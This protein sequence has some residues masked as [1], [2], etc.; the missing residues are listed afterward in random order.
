MVMDKKM[1]KGTASFFLCLC[2]LMQG[3]VAAAAEPPPADRLARICEAPEITVTAKEVFHPAKEN[4]HYE[5]FAPTQL[6][7]IG[8]AYYLV[9]S[10]HNQI[11]CSRRL[12]PPAFKWSV[13]V[14]GLNRPH[15][16]AGDGEVFL[17]ADTDNHRIVSYVRSEGAEGYI[18]KQIFDNVGVRP[19]YIAYDGEEGLFYAWSSMTGEMILFRRKPG[20]ADVALEE[21]KKIS[22]LCGKYVRSFTVEGDR[23][24]FP[25]VEDSAIVS[26]DRETFL[27]KAVYPVP[28]NMAGMVQLVKI[29]NYYYLTVSTDIDYNRNAAVMVRAKSLEDFAVGDYEKVE[30]V[31]E[32]NEVPYYISEA[33]GS[34]Y[35]VV[36]GGSEAACGYRFDVEEDQFRRVRKAA[37]GW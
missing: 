32:V 1:R 18:E 3:S 4:I 34:Y 20:S 22:E 14:D 9:D 23:I 35:T 31:F 7:K 15:A 6:V 13:M 10:Y 12:E 29:Q 28:E 2:V 26:V 5:L 30:G 36:M 8:D 16:I 25:C 21:V 37:E 17:V 19:H 33:D 24:Y 27:V 11:L